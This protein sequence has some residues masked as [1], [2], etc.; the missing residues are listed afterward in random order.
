MAA[1]AGTTSTIY[2]DMFP[3]R[4]N[5][6]VAC[7]IYVHYGFT[8]ATIAYQVQGSLD[9]VNW[10]NGGPSDFVTIAGAP[11]LHVSTPWIYPASFL[12]FQLAFTAFGALGGCGFNLIVRVDHE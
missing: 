5:D 12:R 11:F 10:D 3:M 6:R 1:P 2:T 7:Q 9:G 4:G 8:A